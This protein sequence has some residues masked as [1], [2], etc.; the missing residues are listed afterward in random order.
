MQGVQ[1]RIFHYDDNNRKGPVMKRTVARS[2]GMLSTFGVLMGGGMLAFAYYSPDDTGS[3]IA[4]YEGG[5][6]TDRAIRRSPTGNWD[7]AYSS[8][9]RAEKVQWGIRDIPTR[10]DYDG[11]GKTDRAIWRPSTGNWHVISSS[12]GEHSTVQWGSNG[13]IPAPGDYNGD[14]RTDWVVWRPSTGNWHVIYSYTGAQA[15]YHWKATE[16]P[17]S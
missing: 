14:G 10:G 8:S 17:T 11:D 7:V 1:Q 2:V 6:R 16:I 9:G 4:D 12:T 5:G 3:I 15:T 13:D